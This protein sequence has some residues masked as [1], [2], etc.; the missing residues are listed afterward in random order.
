MNGE[1]ARQQSGDPASSA[2]TENGFQRRKKRKRSQILQAA[3]QLFERHGFKRVSISD[4]ASQARVSQVTIYNHFGSKE[5]LIR[6]VLRTFLEGRLKRYRSIISSSMPY[7]SKLQKIVTDKAALI[8]QFRGELITAVY[9]DDPELIPY[10]EAIQRDI[11]ENSTLPF[12]EE[13]RKLGCVPRDI[14]NEAIA[15]YL[16]VIRTGFMSSPEILERLTSN[17]DLMNQVYSLIL[18]GMIRET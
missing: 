10:I 7:R 16:A 6:E 17:S 3:L 15:L 12:L 8:D 2:N 9:R 18:Y 11:F 1:P 5:S 13:G 4:I 14:G